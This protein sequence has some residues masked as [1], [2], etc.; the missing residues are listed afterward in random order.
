MAKQ[1]ISK[2]TNFS[3]CGILDKRED[4]K[5]IV[6]IESK[7]IGFKEYELDDILEE[8]RGTEIEF[9]SVDEVSVQ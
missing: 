2:T 6:T 3:V 4:G 5:Y 9:K 7:D 1:R 8:M